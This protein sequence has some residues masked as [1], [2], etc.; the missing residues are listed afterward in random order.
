MFSSGWVNTDPA[1]TTD[2]GALTRDDAVAGLYTPATNYGAFNNTRLTGAHSTSSLGRVKAED[3]ERSTK[4]ISVE[5]ASHLTSYEDPIKLILPPV[6]QEASTVFV[7]RKFAVGNTAAEVPE[8][9]QAPVVSGQEESRRV[10]LRRYGGD[11]DFNVNSC[12]VPSLFKREMDLKVGAQHAA[13]AQK[14]ISLGYERLMNDGTDFVTALVRSMGGGIHNPVAS[15]RM[16]R[17]FYESQVFGALGKQ[18]YALANLLAAAKRCTAYDIS[19]S[20]KTVMIL[21]HGVPELMAYSKAE[22]MT[23]RINGLTGPQGKPITLKVESGYKVPASTANVFVHIPPA[24]HMH[25]NVSPHAGTN[26]L[27]SEVVIVLKYTSGTYCTNFMDRSFDSLEGASDDAPKYKILVLKMLHAILAVPGSD[28]GNLLMQYPRSTVSADASTESG[29]MQLRVYMGAVLKRPENVLIMR[30][31]AF[32]GI[33][34]ESNVMTM[35]EIV[36]ENPENCPPD[37][38]DVLN[39][40]R[41]DEAAFDELFQNRFHP[42]NGTTYNA[43]HNVEAS[44]SGSLGHLDDV[45]MVHRLYGS[46]IYDEA[47]SGAVVNNHL[48][49][50]QPA[51][52]PVAPD[53]E[54]DEEEE[55]A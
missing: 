14:L 38:E 48:A 24:R 17:R 16:A 8:R 41:D 18:T 39:T 45:S 50:R 54:E 29:L 22:N 42:Q 20:V 19:R 36:R 49:H 12:A 1:G 47:V 33:V 53:E 6:L 43:Q 9:A 7:T 37:L 35:D 4:I 40:M 25:N 52:P 46:Q 3:I 21:P 10:R 44:N 30:N 55:D 2:G 32:N 23:Y 13:L 5:T 34:F 11:I 26:E 27:E 15:Q 28:T 51:V 31:V